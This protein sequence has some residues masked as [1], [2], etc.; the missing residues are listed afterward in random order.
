[1]DNIKTVYYD[2]RDHGVIAFAL[3]N[4]LSFNYYATCDVV[5][6]FFPYEQLAC[7]KVARDRFHAIRVGVQGL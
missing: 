1:M 7:A 4:G 6:V 3:E 2:F 5:R